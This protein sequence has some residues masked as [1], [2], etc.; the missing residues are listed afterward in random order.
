MFPTQ[1]CPRKVSHKK[2]LQEEC[3]ARV[4]YKDV[5]Q[6]GVQQQCRE[7]VSRMQVTQE[8]P[9]ARV[10]SKSVAHKSAPESVIHVTPKYS[11]KCVYKS[12]KQEC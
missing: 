1:E 2:S 7:R 11:S 9:S 5:G 12:A 4:S 8:R 6:K 10:P 3:P